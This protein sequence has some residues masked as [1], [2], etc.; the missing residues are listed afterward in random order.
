MYIDGGIRG[1]WDQLCDGTPR[2]KAEGLQHVRDVAA[3]ETARRSGYVVGGA[4][5]GALNC[6]ELWMTQETR[7]I[8]M[9]CDWKSRDGE[10]TQ[11]VM[12][13][14]FAPYPVVVISESL[15]LFLLIVIYPY[16]AIGKLPA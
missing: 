10:P 12:K 14:F 6:V 3:I 8:P 15:F 16:S 13:R 4:R 9:E 5:R 1:K 7:M 2:Q 11:R